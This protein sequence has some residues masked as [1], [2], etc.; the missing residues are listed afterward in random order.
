VQLIA[1]RF[2]SARSV[3]DG[4]VIDLATNRDV[5]LRTLPR[6]ANGDQLR[7]SCR[8]DSLLRRR[9]ASGPALVDYGLLGQAS[10]FEAWS[11]MPLSVAEAP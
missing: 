4:R 10:R 7:W 3:G 11:A 8:C 5:R 2:A 9:A 1:D 6:A